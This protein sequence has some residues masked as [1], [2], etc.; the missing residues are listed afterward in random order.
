MKNAVTC[1]AKYS[2]C[3]SLHVFQPV[4]YAL[5][6]YLEQF[7][8]YCVDMSS[9]MITASVD[10]CLKMVLDSMVHVMSSSTNFT[11]D[12]CLA[13]THIANQTEC[14]GVDRLPAVVQYGVKKAEAL[15]EKSYMMNCVP[16]L[17]EM[18]REKGMDAMKDIKLT[19]SKI[20]IMKLEITYLDFCPP[21][22]LQN[23]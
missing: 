7:K 9:A 18:A 12:I 4:A 16:I 1:V 5:R 6:N 22:L 17:E 23:L 14:Q 11:R 15:V 19:E 3:G 20:G 10:P 8:P 2:D 13:F 21:L